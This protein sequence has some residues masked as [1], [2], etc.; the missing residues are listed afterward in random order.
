MFGSPLMDELWYVKCKE[1]T[2]ILMMPVAIHG[3]KD[4]MKMLIPELTNKTQIIKRMKVKS[5]GPHLQIIFGRM[6]TVLHVATPMQTKLS[7]N[8]DAPSL[9]VSE[10]GVL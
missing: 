6:A 5:S 9:Y 4:I 7:S 2:L 1:E 8:K 3:T 10:V